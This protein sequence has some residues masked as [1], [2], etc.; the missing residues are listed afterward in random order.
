MYV[1]LIWDFCSFRL[2]LLVQ[3]GS[4]DVFAGHL[5]G[6]LGFMSRFAFPFDTISHGIIGH[7][8][9]LKR[10]FVCNSFLL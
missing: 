8:R 9:L 1:F 2:S 3:K 7:V 5:G 6:G 4:A 10:F